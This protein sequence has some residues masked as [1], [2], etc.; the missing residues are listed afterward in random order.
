MA[1][2]TRGSL[3]LAAA[4]LALGATTAARAADPYFCRDYARNAVAQAHQAE[5]RPGRCGHLFEGGDRDRW[6]FD[7]EVHYGWCL[8]ASR[9]RADT[10]RSIRRD[11]LIRCEND[12]WGYRHPYYRWRPGY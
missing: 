11:E 7:Y 8:G 5:R 6:S 12:D 2:A 1:M 4:V 10:E 9:E 3:A